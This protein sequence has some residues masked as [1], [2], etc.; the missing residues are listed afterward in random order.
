MDPRKRARLETL[1]Y[2]VTDAAEFL[3]LT[4]EEAEIVEVKVALGDYMRQLRTDR[5][6]TQREV[7][8]RIGSS[9]SRVAKME[10][11]VGSVSIDLMLKALFAMGASRSDLGR[12]IGRPA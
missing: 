2:R 6:W 8:D 1:G 4:P 11:T 5:N 3:G 12:I 10:T 7:A 9:Q